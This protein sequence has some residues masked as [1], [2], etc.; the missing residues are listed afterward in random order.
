MPVLHNSNAKSHSVGWEKV[1]GCG[2]QVII[3]APCGFK[4]EQSLREVDR[5]LSR[6]EIRRLPAVKDERVYVADGNALFSR[7]SPRLVDT[8]ELLAHCIHPSLANYSGVPS[9]PQMMKR[10]PTLDYFLDANK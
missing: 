7:P 6:E 10:L 4:I 5:F 9:H 8:L 3:V 1:A 2:A